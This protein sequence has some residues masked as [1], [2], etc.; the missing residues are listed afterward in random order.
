MNALSRR[1]AKIEAEVIKPEYVPKVVRL[2]VAPLDDSTDEQKAAFDR[3]LARAEAECHM[4]IVLVPLRP[5][6]CVV[7]GN[8][9]TDT[10]ASD[11]RN[12][13]MQP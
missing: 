8:E 3:E 9:A 2:M 13:R 11:M 10:T 12:V 6:Q 5:S 1:L 7:A 4:V